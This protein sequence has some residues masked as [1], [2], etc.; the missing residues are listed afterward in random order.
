MSIEKS[1]ISICLGSAC[2]ARGN[3][4]NLKMIEDFISANKLNIA[5]DLVGSLCT[6]K[7]DKGPYITVNQKEFFEVDALKLE[8]IF[9]ELR[10]K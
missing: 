8:E 5:I 3:A 10:R 2:Y 9:E 1:E 7:C 4:E 6:G